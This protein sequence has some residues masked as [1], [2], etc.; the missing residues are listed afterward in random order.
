[1]EK[2]NKKILMV[3]ATDRFNYGDLLFPIVTR[4]A[5]L[6][7]AR[8]DEIE[9]EFYNFATKKTDLKKYGAYPTESFSRF[10]RKCGQSDSAYH[11][12]V[13][14]G[15]VLAVDWMILY[16]MV[17]YPV[18]LL[19]TKKFYKVSKFRKL[20]QKYVLRPKS[21]FPFVYE[22]KKFPGIKTLS[23]NS[24]GDTYDA[25]PGLLEQIEKHADYFSVRTQADFD[26]ANFIENIRL[27]PDSAILMSDFWVKDHLK[28][29]LNKNFEI[30]T[31][32]YLFF[33][34]NKVHLSYGIDEICLEL[35]KIYHETGLKIILC[36]IG[37]ALK[38]DDHIAL[39]KLASG[40]SVPNKLYAGLTIWEIMYLIANAEIYVG[41]SLHGLITAMSFGIPYVG[42]ESV[43]KQK[44]FMDTWS[45][46]ELKQASTVLTMS[47][48]VSAVMSQEQENLK[49]KIEHRTKEL[50]SL[51]WES[52]S[53]MYK[54]IKS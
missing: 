25:P 53:N 40:L 41:T 10:F 20:Y 19:Q 22:R 50:K 52:M 34:L 2:V 4:E 28:E 27:V 44:N 35:E 18:Y 42:F 47:E 33:Q 39:S 21:D 48:R 23:Y 24:V 38:H 51:V 15:G 49:Q 7:F 1:M 11:V 29:K 3:G 45:I 12:I 13:V 6:T 5:L 9:L 14:G 46:E 26:T 54:L 32:N 17:S 37:T 16:S 30:P 31:E 36:S 43:R 8:E